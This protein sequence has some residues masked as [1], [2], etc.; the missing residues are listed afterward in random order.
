M[1]IDDALLLTKQCC[2][3]INNRMLTIPCF[4]FTMMSSSRLLERFEYSPS[5]ILTGKY[6]RILLLAS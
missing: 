6:S 1:M 3:K 5:S 4:W 2:Q